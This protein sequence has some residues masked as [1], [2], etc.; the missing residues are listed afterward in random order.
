MARICDLYDPETETVTEEDY[1]QITDDDRSPD[2]LW[3]DEDGY[4]WTGR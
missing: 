1:A 4:D 2:P 3:G